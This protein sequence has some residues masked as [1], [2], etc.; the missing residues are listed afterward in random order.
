MHEVPTHEWMCSL[1]PNLVLLAGAV[2]HMHYSD[3]KTLLGG[4]SFK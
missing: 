4:T 3:R 1:D 2:S